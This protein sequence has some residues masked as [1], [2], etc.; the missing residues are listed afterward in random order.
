MF[1]ILW[2]YQIIIKSSSMFILL[3]TNSCWFY[4][5]S[6]FWG[7]PHILIPN[8]IK[9]IKI[10]TAFLWVFFG[11]PIICHIIL[12]GSFPSSCVVEDNILSLSRVKGSTLTA[13][14]GSNIMHTQTS[15]MRILLVQKVKSRW[16]KGDT[17]QGSPSITGIGRALHT[18]KLD[19]L[20]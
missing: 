5:S 9:L 13:R 15:N 17:H 18:Q 7:N 12:E 20:R 10:P 19:W 1:S 16:Q 3:P 8:L 11:S 14:L 2:V 4:S 6:L